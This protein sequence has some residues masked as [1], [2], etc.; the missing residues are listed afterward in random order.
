MGL[1]MQCNPAP[2]PSSPPVK[3]FQCFNFPG[4]EKYLKLV[5]VTLD[6]N[7]I[8]MPVSLTEPLIP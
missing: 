5:L 8:Y 2:I 6:C 3:S 4:N 1:A 7:F